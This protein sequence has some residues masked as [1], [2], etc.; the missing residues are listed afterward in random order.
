MDIKKFKLEEK[1]KV[2]KN[3][4]AL[5]RS[6]APTSTFQT[7]TCY[8]STALYFSREWLNFRAHRLYQ[9]LCRSTALYINEKDLGRSSSLLVPLFSPKDS[10]ITF[11]KRQ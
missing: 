6:R 3:G 4:G 11:Q 8:T 7:S 10:K 5:C 9:K 2:S 1:K